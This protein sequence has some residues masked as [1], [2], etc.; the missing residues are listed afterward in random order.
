MSWKLWLTFSRNFSKFSFLPVKMLQSRINQPRGSSATAALQGSD[1]VWGLCTTLLLIQHHLG[2]FHHS[3]SQHKSVYTFVLQPCHRGPST[4]WGKKK[5]L[6]IPQANP[7]DSLGEAQKTHPDFIDAI[8]HQILAGM[9]P[10]G[11]RSLTVVLLIYHERRQAG[12]APSDAGR[13]LARA[14]GLA[15]KGCIVPVLN[16]SFLSSF[17]YCWHEHQGA[18]ALWRCK[19]PFC[20]LPYRCMSPQGQF[21]ISLG[22]YRSDLSPRLQTLYRQISMEVQ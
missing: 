7:V 18:L 4:M 17:C 10:S 15:L 14:L 16:N 6:L 22:F 2:H 11:D 1:P 5:S 3:A 12:S 13:S 8:S 19:E 21:H 9:C 20:F